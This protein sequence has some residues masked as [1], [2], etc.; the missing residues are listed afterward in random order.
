MNYLR[1][2]RFWPAVLIVLAACGSDAAVKSSTPDP[3]TTTTIAASS[4]TTTTLAT[5]TTV[6]PASVA[7]FRACRNAVPVILAGVASNSPTLLQNAIDVC[8][9][10]KD[11]LGDLPEPGANDA[12]YALLKITIQLDK[13]KLEIGGAGDG[14]DQIAKTEFTTAVLDF[15]TA[16]RIYLGN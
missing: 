6:E 10:A 14:Y 15:L 5:T 16:A 13:A 1:A 9:K 11:A 8:A 3:T 2:M 4:P 7:A 12:G